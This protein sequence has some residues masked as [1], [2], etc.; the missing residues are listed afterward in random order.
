M[1][2]VMKMI[3]NSQMMSMI[4]VVIGC[5]VIIALPFILYR[6]DLKGL[7]KTYFTGGLIFFIGETFIRYPIT[8]KLQ[9]NNLALNILIY[10]AVSAVLAIVFRVFVLNGVLKQNME[11]NPTKTGLVLGMGQMAMNSMVLAITAFSNYRI[12]TM[13]NNGTIYDL[14][15][16]ELT[17]DRIDEGIVQLQNV[18]EL[19]LILSVV[20]QFIYVVIMAGLGLMVVRAL[21]KKDYKNLL[22]PGLIFIALYAIEAILV[23]TNQPALIRIL[24]LAVLGAVMGYYLFNERT[25]GSNHVRV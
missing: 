11:E 20:N 18:S 9:V 3:R 5:L 4:F 21:L 25:R 6:K 14:V 10:A 15:T 24:A 17:R 23:S 22:Y 2:K 1:S 13:I 19:E 12:G 7:L 8:Q 16:E